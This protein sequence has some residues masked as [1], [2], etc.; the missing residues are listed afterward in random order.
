MFT[1][2]VLHQINYDCDKSIREKEMQFPNT[3]AVGIKA[4]SFKMAHI[5]IFV[6]VHI[7][8]L[9]IVIYTL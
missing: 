2:V 6:A 8:M 5:I 4:L 9:Y 1:F 3:Y 7:Y